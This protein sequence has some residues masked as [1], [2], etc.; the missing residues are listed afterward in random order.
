MRRLKGG[1]EGGGREGGG[2]GG[3]GR[4][5][6]RSSNTLTKEVSLTELQSSIGEEKEIDA[7]DE[8]NG[9]I[10]GRG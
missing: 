5:D 8:L 9:F 1:R 7:T 4:R 10:G 2:G 6:W 3:R